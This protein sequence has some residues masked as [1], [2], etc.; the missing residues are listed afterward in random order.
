M[1]TNLLLENLKD[2]HVAIALSGDTSLPSNF[3]EVLQE[4]WAKIV[5]FTVWDDGS[6]TVITKD[7]VIAPSELKLSEEMTAWQVLR[8]KRW[9]LEQEEGKI[10][11]I[12]ATS[13]NAFAE[14]VAGLLELSKFRLP[15]WLQESD[16]N[17]TR[18]AVEELV[19]YEWKNYGRCQKIT[20]AK[21]ELSTELWLTKDGKLLEIT[22]VP[23]FKEKCSGI[24]EI[25]GEKSEVRIMTTKDGIPS[26]KWIQSLE[27]LKKSTK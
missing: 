17:I 8:W 4:M 2:A 16:Y 12:D 20:V 6:S 27:T 25:S 3:T 5:R 11:D 22:R 14:K 21:G 24:K 7:I 9:K 15:T 23:A 19:H 13:A 26:V 18:W 10:V 1:A